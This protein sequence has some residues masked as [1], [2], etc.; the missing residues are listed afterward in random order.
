MANDTTITGDVRP[1]PHQGSAVMT[2]VRW[3]DLLIGLPLVIATL[4]T[5]VPLAQ[6]AGWL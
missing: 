5:F 2:T 3:L 1:R 6:M 4:V